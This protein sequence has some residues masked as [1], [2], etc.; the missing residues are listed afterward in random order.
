MAAS[1][2]NVNQEVASSQGFEDMVCELEN[3]DQWGKGASEKRFCTEYVL[4]CGPAL[5]GGEDNR[6]LAF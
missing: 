6:V 1:A 2:E 3:G 4:S 5:T